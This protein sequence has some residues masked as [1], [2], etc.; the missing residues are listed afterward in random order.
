MLAFD[1]LVANQDRTEDNLLCISNGSMVLVDHAD[2]AG[3][4]SREVDYLDPSFSPANMFIRDT[5]E[6]AIPGSITSGMVMAAE[7]H[8]QVIQNALPH[9]FFWFN[10]L[11]PNAPERTSKLL[12]FLKTR[13]NTSADRIKRQYGILI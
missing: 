13:A 2:I 6:G 9:I 5:F 4:I 3:G 12:D 10:L 7:Q 1:D 11:F 8:P